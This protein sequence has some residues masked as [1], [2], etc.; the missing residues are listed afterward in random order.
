MAERE[1]SNRG[2]SRSRPEA[3]KIPVNQCG[4]SGGV[5]VRDKVASLLSE[6]VEGGVAI[7]VGV[8]ATEYARAPQVN[9]GSEW[10]GER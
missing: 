9:L 5:R 1:Q 8:P 2:G 6:L 10:K 4:L 7:I 3:E